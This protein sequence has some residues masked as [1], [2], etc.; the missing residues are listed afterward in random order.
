MMNCMVTQSIIG[1]GCFVE[2]STI[3]HSVIGLR[4]LIHAGCTI[5]VL[6]ADQIDCEDNSF[7]AS[8]IVYL[9]NIIK[10]DAKHVP[11]IA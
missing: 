5:E 10:R 7:V 4:S 9:V 2:N 11:V 3:T 8:W 6:T 1:D